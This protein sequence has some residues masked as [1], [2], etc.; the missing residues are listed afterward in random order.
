MSGRI[1]SRFYAPAVVGL[2]TALMA[3]QVYLGYFLDGREQLDVATLAEPW[4][5]HYELE[6]Q[7]KRCGFLTERLAGGSGGSW[8]RDS[9]AFISESA[10]GLGIIGN[11][12]VT[13]GA[14]ESL[15]RIDLRVDSLA[16]TVRVHAV[17]EQETLRVDVSR[18]GQA[19]LAGISLPAPRATAL[20]LEL[21]LLG[22]EKLDGPVSQQVALP[23]APGLPF[24]NLRLHVEPVPASSDAGDGTRGRAV[25]VDAEGGWL[26]LELGPNNR[27]RRL[28]SSA[29]LSMSA[30]PASVIRRYAAERKSLIEQ[31]AG[32]AAEA[33]P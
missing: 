17:R 20:R 31:L 3:Y 5:S 19:I 18:D 28:T 16:G 8:V 2:W 9:M 21:P 32:Q 11:S 25:R 30:A 6:W 23:D 10:F 1:W 14:N 27:F 4:E 15:E 29:G 12:T 13:L 33:T 22:L 26:R 24:R 7:G